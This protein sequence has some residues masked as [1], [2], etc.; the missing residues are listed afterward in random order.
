MKKGAK[1]NGQLYPLKR[2]IERQPTEALLEQA[3]AIWKELN[4]NAA[5]YL[6]YRIAEMQKLTG[7]RPSSAV[8]NLVRQEAEALCDA[9]FLRA[10]AV[11]D[12]GNADPV[13]RGRARAQLQ[14][15]HKLAAHARA[16]SREA[17]ALAN[18]EKSRRIPPTVTSAKSLAEELSSED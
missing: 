12:L 7:K 6:R 15:A 4:T 14:E 18:A 17:W 3:P 5:Q 2:H 11:A 9:A 1:T 16:A 13:E 8:A 10:E